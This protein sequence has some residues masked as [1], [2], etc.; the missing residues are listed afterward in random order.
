MKKLIIFIAVMLFGANLINVNFFPQKNKIDVLFSLDGKFNGKVIQTQ[1]NTFLITNI[2]ADKKVEKFFDKYFL[3]K[4][5]IL[6][7]ANG[8]LVKVDSNVKYS[9][10]VALTPDGY[11]L[12]FRIKS[13]NTVSQITKLDNSNPQKGLDY[14]SYILSISVLLI[15][16]I[17]LFIFK[18]KM[19]KKLPTTKLNVTILFQKPLD[20][21][22]RIALIEFNKRKYLVL[23]GNTNILLDVFDENMV[24]VKTQQE[25]DAVLEQNMEKL[26]NFKQYIQNAEKLKEFDEK[27]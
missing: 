14:F 5:V 6:P 23:I 22:N 20:P 26:D 19:V 2:T 18:R 16:A 12:R 24:N 8:I 4:L 1:K 13:L 25:F 27:V 11:G 10:S 21:K 3:Q 7:A 9:T 17:T 15:I